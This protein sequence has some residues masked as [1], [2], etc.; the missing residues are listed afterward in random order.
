MDS[1]SADIKLVFGR[2]PHALFASVLVCALLLNVGCAGGGAASGLN[3]G[4]D[5]SDRMSVDAGSVV[6]WLQTLGPGGYAPGTGAD[7]YTDPTV[8]GPATAVTTDV[9]VL[10]RGGAITLDLETPI[11][12]GEGAELAVWEN[13]IAVD[14]RLFAELAYVEVSSD[15]V[16]FAR[17]PVACE[18]DQKVSAYGSLDTALY[19]GFAGL[20]E[21]GTGTA[22]DL[23]KLAS[24]PAVTDGHVDLGAIRYVRIVDVI[25]D[26]S[27]TDGEGRPIYDPYPTSGTAGF[28]L[29]AVGVLT[30]Q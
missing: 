4:D 24:L 17:F 5:S 25:G 15:G 26:G 27:E 13:G 14:N 3:E 9:V 6:R 28:D 12:E 1:V 8:L 23:G 2:L 30:S 29:N 22:F 20:H 16:V 18:N 11:S 10:G 7:T 19:S 21:A